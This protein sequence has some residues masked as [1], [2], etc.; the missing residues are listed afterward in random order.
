MPLWSRAMWYVEFPISFTVM[1]S[2]SITWEKYRECHWKNHRSILM[3]I[4]AQAN[5]C[6]LSFIIWFWSIKV[7]KWVSYLYAPSINLSLKIVLLLLEK[8]NTIS[9]WISVKI[10]ISER[11]NC[12]RIPQVPAVSFIIFL[13]RLLNGKQFSNIKNTYVDCYFWKA[14]G[15]FNIFSRF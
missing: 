15:I 14:L 6:S 3:S 7:N 13:L 9:V 2:C 5:N 11:L 4:L 10:N 1:A 8:W 12:N